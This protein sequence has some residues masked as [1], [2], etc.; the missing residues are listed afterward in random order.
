MFKYKITAT[1]I[2]NFSKQRAI[3][4]NSRTL[5]VY[6]DTSDNYFI[7]YGSGLHTLSSGWTVTNAA[8]LVWSV[9]VN[10]NACDTKKRLKNS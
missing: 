2:F 1:Q 10:L 5:N 4:L 7:F 9:A 3:L 6:V 8:G